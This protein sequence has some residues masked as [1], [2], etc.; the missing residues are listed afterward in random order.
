[1]KMWLLRSNKKS[2][3]FSSCPTEAKI[4]HVYTIFSLEM[5][6]LLFWAVDDPGKHSHSSLSESSSS[7]KLSWA[8]RLCLNFF[9]ILEL[10]LTEVCLGDGVPDAFFETPC[11]PL[12]LVFEVDM[13]LSSVPRISMHSSKIRFDIEGP[14]PLIPVGEHHKVCT[15]SYRVFRVESALSVCVSF[16]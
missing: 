8:W 15:M 7:S 4:V 13:L 10:F 11:M 5:Y 16:S 12:V 6:V 1:M 2:F 14:P 9:F 3:N